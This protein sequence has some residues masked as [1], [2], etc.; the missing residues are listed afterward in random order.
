[1]GQMKES[2]TVIFYS[3]TPGKVHLKMVSAFGFSHL[4]RAANILASTFSSTHS[5]AMHIFRF[6]QLTERLG[7]WAFEIYVK[8]YWG[9][10][11]VSTHHILVI[12]NALNLF[13]NNLLQKTQGLTNLSRNSRYP[14]LS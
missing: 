10:G 7:D 8:P 1:M 9:M 14:I 11:I 12:R 13:Y 2:Y 6:H 4:V 5:T 3:S